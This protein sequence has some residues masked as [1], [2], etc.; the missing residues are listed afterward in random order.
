LSGISE[1]LATI[2]HGPGN[3]NIIVTVMKIV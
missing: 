2:L 3:A 1:V